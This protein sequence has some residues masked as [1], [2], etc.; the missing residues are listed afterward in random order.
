MCCITRKKYTSIIEL[1]GM[2]DKLDVKILLL[3]TNIRLFII[4]PVIIDNRLLML[5]TI[6][7]DV[8]TNSGRSNPISTTAFMIYFPAVT[9]PQVLRIV[10]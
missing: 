6:L 3:F 8:I 10:E 7:M 4:F 9:R 1:A 5:L 2:V